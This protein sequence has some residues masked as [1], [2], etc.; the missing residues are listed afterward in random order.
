MLGKIKNYFVVISGV[1]RY[2]INIEATKDVIILGF[3][4][5]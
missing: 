3:Q 1:K 2:Y 5:Y 4:Q